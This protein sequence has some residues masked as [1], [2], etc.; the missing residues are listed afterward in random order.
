MA[1]QEC[2]D[3]KC[4][5]HGQLKV[6]GRSF[7]G[8]VKSA[9]MHNTVTVEFERPFLVRK[10]NRY[11]RRFTR[12]KAHKPGCM[13]LS[14]GQKVEVWECRPL[15]KTKSFVVTKIMGEESK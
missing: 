7:V 8:T 15:S 11:E 1:S 2:M 10:Y 14:E 9:K 5:I 6:R 4:P 3:A 13:S 12:I